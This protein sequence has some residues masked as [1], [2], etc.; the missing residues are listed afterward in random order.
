MLWLGS[1]GEISP[2][3]FLSRLNWGI[4]ISGIGVWGIGSGAA[5]I[6]VLGVAVLWRRL[7]KRPTA[8]EMERRRR[9]FLVQSGRIVDG[10]LLDVHDVEA[11]DGRS[12]TMLLYNYRVAGVDYECSQ[13]IGALRSPAEVEKIQLG[14]PCTVRYQPG[15]PQNSIVVAETWCGLRSG[16]PKL[17]LWKFGNRRA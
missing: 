10:T 16:V 1:R 3:M 6:A 14:F 9:D 8:E 11:E 13:E 5:V 4:G 17:P 7:H 15:N 12:L 2:F